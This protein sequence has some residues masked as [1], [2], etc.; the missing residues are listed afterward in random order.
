MD[1][2][3]Q[4][5]TPMMDGAR[6]FVEND[7]NMKETDRSVGGAVRGLVGSRAPLAGIWGRGLNFFLRYELG[8]WLSSHDLS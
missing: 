5:T 4:N 8:F 2:G 3:T 6:I 1:I 7:P